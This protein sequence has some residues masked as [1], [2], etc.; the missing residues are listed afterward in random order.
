[1]RIRVWNENTLRAGEL[2]WRDD[3]ADDSGDSRTIVAESVAEAESLAVAAEHEAET[4]ASSYLT[5][6]AA[7]IRDNADYEMPGA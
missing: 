7:T 2:A 3:E 6:L 5:T 4:R 1:M